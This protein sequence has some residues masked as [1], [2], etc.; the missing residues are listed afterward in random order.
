MKRTILVGALLA[1]LF[2]G[3]GC[4]AWNGQREG[5]FQVKHLTLEANNF[6]VLKS[7]IQASASC[8]YLFPHEAMVIMGMPLL[9]AGGIALGNPELYE[10][11]YKKLREQAALEGKSAQI[12]NVT[13]EVTM[14]SYIVIGD[15]KLTLTADV[16]E[17]TGEYVDYASRGK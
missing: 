17:F 8:S 11:A 3:A 5:E 10:T 2:V 6:K 12:F 4:T 15:I 13:E 7:K 14:T 9:P 1:G 16:I